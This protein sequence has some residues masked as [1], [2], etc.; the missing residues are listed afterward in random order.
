MKK[1]A[2][3]EAS[4]QVSSRKGQDSSSC[5]TNFSGYSIVDGMVSVSPDPSAS[6]SESG[7][8]SRGTSVEGAVVGRIKKR[9]RS[10]GVV[11]EEE[12]PVS[13]DFPFEGVLLRLCFCCLSER[14]RELS[15][16]ADK[17]RVGN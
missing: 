1:E 12:A 16:A 8:R 14:Y 13:V 10:E 7:P 11:P 6:H 2:V 4:L 17:Y 9:A 15:V 5:K 3:L